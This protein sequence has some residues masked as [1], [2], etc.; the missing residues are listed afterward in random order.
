MNHNAKK[1]NEYSCDNYEECFHDDDSGDNGNA[2]VPDGEGYDMELDDHKGDDYSES[3]TI[4]DGD[5][6]AAFGG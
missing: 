4:V 2:S 5:F 1:G 3:Q 6:F